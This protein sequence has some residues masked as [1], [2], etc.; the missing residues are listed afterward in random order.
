VVLQQ[1]AY[2]RGN[3]APRMRPKHS[4]AERKFLIIMK[5]SHKKVSSSSTPIDESTTLINQA[6]KALGPVPRLSPL[7]RR[8]SAKTRRG[9][10][11]VV[12]LIAAVATKYGIAA[13]AMTGG[14]LSASLAR[15]QALDPLLSA[16]AESHATISDAHFSASNE[17]WTSARA[18]YR[19]L[20]TV[21]ETNPSIATELKPVEEWFRA[22][23]SAKKQPEATSTTP[24][25]AATTTTNAAT[26]APATVVTPAAASVA[27]TIVAKAP[28]A[29]TPPTTG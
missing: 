25:T 7:E 14:S 5:S 27:T 24:A 29:V 23:R 10:H 4:T 21:G 11:Q 3:P 28:T 16:S 19:M 20:K 6:T 15:V 8:R 17:M 9:G 18:L 26:T 12:P 2:P 13:P 22:Q 1:K